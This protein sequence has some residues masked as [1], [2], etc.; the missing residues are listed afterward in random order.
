MIILSP[1][2]NN[3]SQTCSFIN[4]KMAYNINKKHIN[5]KTKKQFVFQKN[6]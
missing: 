3:L 4:L 6:K 1:K 5:L 2:K